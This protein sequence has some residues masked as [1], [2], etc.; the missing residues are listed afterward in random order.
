MAPG[1][2]T[3]FAPLLGGYDLFIFDM[4]GVLWHG[5]K[6]VAGAA[7]A[8]EVLRGARKQIRFVTNNAADHRSSYVEKLAGCGIKADVD[9][10]FSSA[11]SAAKVVK[12]ELN[13]T[14]AFVLGMK[15]LKRELE[16][17]GVRVSGGP[18]YVPPPT[19]EEAQLQELDLSIDAVVAGVD[20]ELSYKKIMYASFLLQEKGEGISFVATNRDA[21]GPTSNG[22]FA[23]GGG[24]TVI[25]VETASGRAPDVVAGKPSQMILELILKETGVPP[26]RALMVGDRLDTDIAFGNGGG[27]DTLL[28]LSGCTSEAGLAAAV[29]ASD[30]GQG[31]AR[32]VPTFVADS[33]RVLG[34]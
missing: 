18:D 31:A 17:V 15:G 32:F 2:L 33:V 11:S 8:L 20:H 1:R 12:Q 34:H 5:K 16:D 22:R 23:P 10:V 6:A 14:H 3:S 28:V 13:R 26:A 24:V 27:T 9:E 30:S 29:A 4:D 21:H 7:E 19:N 25:S